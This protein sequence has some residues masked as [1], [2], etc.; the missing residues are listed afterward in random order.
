M[1]V[2][3]I[4]DVRRIFLGCA[5]AMTVRESR[6]DEIEMA[7]VVRYSEFAAPSARAMNTFLIN[8]DNAKRVEVEDRWN[9][10]DVLEE[11]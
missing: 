4:I 3:A 6:Y 9:G 7:S 2:F 10:G 11:L 5:W 8:D 1:I